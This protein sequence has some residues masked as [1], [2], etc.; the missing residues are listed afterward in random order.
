E[1]TTLRLTAGCSAIELLRS[2][3][4]APA[5][6]GPTAIVQFIIPSS[7]LAANIAR[8]G[9]QPSVSLLQ[10]AS[11]VEILALPLRIDFTA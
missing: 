5:A 2:V 1:P 3:A 7:G 4:K 10:I 8:K 9:Q 6:A 11:G